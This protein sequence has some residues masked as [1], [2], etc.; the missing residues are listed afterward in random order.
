MR[1]Q[2]QMSTIERRYFSGDTLAQAVMTAAR[3]FGLGPEQV[4][5]RQIEKRHCFLKA[6]CNTK[7]LSPIPFRSD[8]V[9]MV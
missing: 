2:R 6:A 1:E 9:V 4:D 8:R 3:H 7:S 5:Y